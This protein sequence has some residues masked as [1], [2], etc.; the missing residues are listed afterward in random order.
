MAHATHGLPDVS[1][2]L[3]ATIVC[4]ARAIQVP[5]ERQLKTSQCHP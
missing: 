2:A 4:N 5:G 3:D 1:A